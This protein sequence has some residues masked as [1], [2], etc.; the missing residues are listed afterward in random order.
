MTDEFLNRLTTVYA[1]H[2]L[3]AASILERVHRRKGTLDGLTETDLCFDP[4]T[5]VTD[6]NHSGGAA[7][8]IEIGEIVGLEKGMR[9]IDVGTGLGGAPRVISQ[10]YGCRSVGIELTEG[11]YCDAVKLTRLVGL[12]HLVTMVRGDFLTLELDGDSFNLVL[13]QGSFNHFQDMDRL[14]ARSA[15]VLRFGGHLVMEESILLRPVAD[16]QEGS[17]I[18]A[19]GDCWNGWF[20]TVE[21]W[22]RGMRRTGLEVVSRTDLSE[23]SHQSVLETLQLVEQGRMTRSNATELNGWRWAAALAGVGLLGYVRLMARRR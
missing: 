14:L 21:E 17:G 5:H 3:S 13:G 10:R 6:Q 9:V 23:A 12:D 19:L 7:A 18:E 4:E 1:E 16:S 2:P 8:V 20:R 15:E 11:R 22:M